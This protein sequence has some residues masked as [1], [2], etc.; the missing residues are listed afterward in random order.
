MEK[1]SRS[2][3]N[4]PNALIRALPI[5]PEP[6]E[7]ALNVLPAAMRDCVAVFICEINRVHHLA[8]DIELQ[9]L[10]SR[11]SNKYRPRILVSTEM[12]QWNLIKFLP[13]IER[14][15]YLQWAALGIVAQP[16]FQPFNERFGLV[17]EA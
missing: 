15:H 14:V 17:H 13:A 6:L 9:L 10:I 3:P 8:I 4:L 2:A 12:I 16:V 7:D 11:I 5:L 1:F